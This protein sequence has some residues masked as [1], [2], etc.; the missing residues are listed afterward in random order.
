MSEQTKQ[1][2]LYSNTVTILD[3]YECLSLGATTIGNLIDEKRII[4]NKVKTTIKNKGKK[5]DVLIVDSSKKVIAYIEC[6]KPEEFTTE[7]KIEAAINQEIDVARELGVKIFVAT[8]G[9]K[10]V[11]VNALT[12]NKILDENGNKNPNVIKFI[13]R[14]GKNYDFLIDNQKYCMSFCKRNKYMF[15]S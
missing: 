15:T 11:W 3:K 5:P 6:K 10:F 9:T 12:G 13:L 1:N 14:T 7:K 2:D 8:D 4:C